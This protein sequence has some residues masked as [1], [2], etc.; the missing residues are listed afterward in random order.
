MPEIAAPIEYQIVRNLQTALMAMTASDGYNY[1]IAESA[2]KLDPSYDIESFV[3]TRPLRPYVVLHV[4][5]EVRSYESSAKR[6]KLMTPVDI[7]WV[8]DAPSVTDDAQMEMYFRGCADV[9]RAIT[10]DLSLGGLASNITI[11]NRERT[12][13]D[14]AEVRALIHTQILSHR[15]YGEA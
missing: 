12:G 14:G 8:N 6:I 10:R 11:I 13:P 2:V 7:Y 3:G 1:S 5:P 15:I 4:L 9:E